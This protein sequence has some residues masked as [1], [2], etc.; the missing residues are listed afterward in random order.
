MG[1]GEGGD[2]SNSW[3]S[4]NICR[5]IQYKRIAS[6]RA[7]TTFAVFRPRRIIRRKIVRATPAH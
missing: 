7:I 1:E 4:R 5:H 6:R 3:L 2:G